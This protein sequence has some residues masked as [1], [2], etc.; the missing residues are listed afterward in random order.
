[1]CIKI[2]YRKVYHGYINWVCWDEEREREK[3]KPMEEIKIVLF[4]INHFQCS[5][6]VPNELYQISISV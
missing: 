2:C 3:K 4:L 1:M 6:T 5:C